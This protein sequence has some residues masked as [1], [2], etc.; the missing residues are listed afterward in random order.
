M[1]HPLEIL[2]IAV[3]AAVDIPDNRRTGCLSGLAVIAAAA[4]LVFLG[5][6]L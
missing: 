3:Q 5:L 2:V 4:L 1:S 6:L